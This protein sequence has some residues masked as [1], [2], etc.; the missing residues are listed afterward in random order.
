M[1]PCLMYILVYIFQTLCSKPNLAQFQDQHSESVDNERHLQQRFK[2]HIGSSGLL[3]SHFHDC[4]ISPS[5]EM[6]KILGKQKF[7]KLLTLEA[8][9]IS[10]IKPALNTKDEFKSRNLLLKF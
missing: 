1:T 9:F 2:E 7:E 8:L 10:Q 6:V 4:N 3:K 5:F